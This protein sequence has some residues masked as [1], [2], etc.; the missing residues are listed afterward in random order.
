LTA[1]YCGI[2]EGDWTQPNITGTSS[3]TNESI[4]AHP[5]FFSVGS[6]SQA[7]SIAGN[8]PYT[9]A[10]SITKLS[11]YTDRGTVYEGDNG[12]IFETAQ[13]GKFL[14]FYSKA[15]NQARK[16]YGRTSYLAPTS[17]Y[18]G[19]LYTTKAENAVKVRDFVGNSMAARAPTGFRF[20]L[21]AYLG[22]NWSS[23]DE[24]GQLLIASAH[25]EDYGVLYKISYELRYNK[26]GW[27]STV[28]Q[29]FL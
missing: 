14:G 24:D 18:N 1:H 8:P 29:K 20:L 21:P 26:E 12:A 7:R 2:A 9:T 3:L 16:L 27:A 17:S 10:F 5:A 6:G 22:D 13:G 19:V 23:A 4:T 28:Y 15:N 25:F 11:P